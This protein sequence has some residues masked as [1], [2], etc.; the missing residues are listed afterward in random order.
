M[1]YVLMR[2]PHPNHSFDLLPFIILISN[3]RLGDCFCILSMCITVICNVIVR[4]PLVLLFAQ[5]ETDQEQDGSAN[6]E[7]LPCSI[8]RLPKAWV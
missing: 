5:W 2:L 1:V 4:S 8:S 7:C 3:P 6:L